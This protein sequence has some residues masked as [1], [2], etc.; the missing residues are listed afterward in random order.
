MKPKSTLHF[1]VTG[2]LCLSSKFSFQLQ[3]KSISSISYKKNVLLIFAA[4]IFTQNT[5]SAQTEKKNLNPASK[6]VISIT[7]NSDAP[8]TDKVHVYKLKATNISSKDL[9]FKLT[10][11]NINCIGK[12]NSTI[13]VQVFLAGNSESLSSTSSTVI[14]SPGGSLE[15]YVKLIR[16]ANTLLNTWNCTE[17]KAIGQNNLV[18][19]EGTIIESFIP[20]PADFR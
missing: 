7:Q 16:P 14:I 10:A 17:V 12:I 19:S 11:A 2:I 6:I 20:D 9:S 1:F 3:Q 8:H 13:D 18:L 15:F 5:T 4:L